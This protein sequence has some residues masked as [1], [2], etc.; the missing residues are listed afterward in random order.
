MLSTAFAGAAS[1]GAESVAVPVDAVPVD[2][3]SVDTESVEAASVGAEPVAAVKPPRV[4]AA[5]A[6][7]VSVRAMPA[8]LA[9]DEVAGVSDPNDGRPGMNVRLGAPTSAGGTVWLG[10]GIDATGGDGTVRSVVDG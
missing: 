2:A 10:S 7:E 1:A 5:A 8:V 3:E 9:R 4:T 6:A